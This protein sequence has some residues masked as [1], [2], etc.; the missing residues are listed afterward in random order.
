MRAWPRTVALLPLS[1]PHTCPPPPASQGANHVL[2]VP[3]SGFNELFVKVE[4]GAG[5]S[6]MDNLPGSSSSSS[7]S[8]ITA[9]G[10][11]TASGS[12]ASSA[13]KVGCGLRVGGCWLVECE[14]HGAAAGRAQW[15]AAISKQQ[16]ASCPIPH[17]HSS[18]PP[19]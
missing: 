4:W 12:S 3:S 9:N 7:S 6:V 1:H 2:L 18:S 5:T 13:K 19:M 16:A 14:G 11:S 10:S 15:A 17:S 8:S